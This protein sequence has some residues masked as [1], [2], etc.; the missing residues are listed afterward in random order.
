MPAP[1]ILI[2]L[3]I[4]P[5]GHPREDLGAWTLTTRHDRSGT[6]GPAS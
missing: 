4:W 6:S 2:A 5:A 1:L 3:L